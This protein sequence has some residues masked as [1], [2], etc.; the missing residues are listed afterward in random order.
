LPQTGPEGI[1]MSFSVEYEVIGEPSRSADYVWVIERE[2][3]KPAKG[4][5]KLARQATL[6]IF[7][8]GW[9]PQEGPFHLHFEDRRGNRLS[10]TIELP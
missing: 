5:V 3:G 2:H 4:L 9:R 1:L 10:A 7:I 8:N 6:P